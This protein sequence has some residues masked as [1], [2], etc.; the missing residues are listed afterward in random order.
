M[1]AHKINIIDRTIGGIPTIVF[2]FVTD[3][4][5]V[6]ADNIFMIEIG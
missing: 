2:L 6:Y 5:S 4:V 1:M 3:P